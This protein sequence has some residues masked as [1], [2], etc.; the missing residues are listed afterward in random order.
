MPHEKD[1]RVREEGEDPDTGPLK[2]AAEDF[3]RDEIETRDLV[4]KIVKGDE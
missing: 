1:A 2:K 4:L 3:E